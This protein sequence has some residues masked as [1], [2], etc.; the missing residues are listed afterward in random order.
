V[1]VYSAGKETELPEVTTPAMAVVT[2]E[3]V[4]PPL[5]KMEKELRG[6]AYP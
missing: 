6:L 4:K 5:E 1:N 3:E 2:E